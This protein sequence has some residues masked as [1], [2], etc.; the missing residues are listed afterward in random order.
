LFNFSNRKISVAE[1]T[2]QVDSAFNEL[3]IQVKDVRKCMDA[4]KQQAPFISP[5]KAETR[6]HNLREKL[7]KKCQYDDNVIN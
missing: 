4:S 6:I 7:Q 1:N 3:D 2:I 5:N